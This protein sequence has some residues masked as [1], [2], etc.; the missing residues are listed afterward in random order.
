MVRFKDKTRKDLQDMVLQL[1]RE[2]QRLEARL[3]KY[4]MEENDNE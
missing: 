2:K 3:L 4:V 1:E